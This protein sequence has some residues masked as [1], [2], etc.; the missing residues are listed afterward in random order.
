VP[1]EHVDLI[2]QSV[3]HR[4]AELHNL[5]A[6][7]SR[8]ENAQNADVLALPRRVG[9]MLAAP[10][11]MLNVPEC[12]LGTSHTK[13]EKGIMADFSTKTGGSWTRCVRAHVVSMAGSDMGMTSSCS[14]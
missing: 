2:Q 1:A 14:A 12:A 13:R 6:Y 5:V 8:Y 7:E 3:E 10:H 9:L 11:A 4:A